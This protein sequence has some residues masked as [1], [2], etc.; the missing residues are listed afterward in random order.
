MKFQE[1]V[2]FIN[3]LVSEGL[4][5]EGAFRFAVSIYGWNEEN[6]NNLTYWQFGMD[7][8]QTKEDYDNGEL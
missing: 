1:K 6:M 8:E 5:N 7:V 3:L 4:I 2:E